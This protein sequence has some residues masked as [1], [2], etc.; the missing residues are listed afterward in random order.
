MKAA[1]VQHQR[2]HMRA[3]IDWVQCARSAGSASSRQP[4]SGRAV[5]GQCGST[6]CPAPTW[7]AASSSSYTGV[8][9]SR[10][11]SSSGAFRP[12]QQGTAAAGIKVWRCIS[13]PW[14]EAACRSSLHNC[15][16]AQLQAK[17]VCCP[18]ASSVKGLPE[19]TQAHAWCAM[20]VCWPL[21]WRQSLQ[22]ATLQ[23]SRACCL[24]SGELRGH[25]ASPVVSCGGMLPHQW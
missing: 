2:M 20:H 11:T 5:E 10:A 7:R 3:A 15:T 24:T 1:R 9:S 6:V 17:R 13:F 22:Q 21:W 19:P 25:A 12:E 23:P 16:R 4:S 8:P 18:T 14:R